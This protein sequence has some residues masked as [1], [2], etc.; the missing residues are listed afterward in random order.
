[1]IQ[2]SKHVIFD[3]ITYDRDQ[4]EIFVKQFDQCIVNYSE[5]QKRQNGGKQ[6]YGVP[7]GYNVVDTTRLDGLGPTEYSE[8]S[9]LLDKFKI[10]IP[11]EHVVISHY[12]VGFRLRPHT[13]HAC[14]ASIMF[15]I[16]PKDAGAELVFHD[17]DPP[18]KKAHDYK[19]FW[20]KI[21]Y[22]VKYSTEHPS[23]FSTQI[24]H[25][26]AT[27]QEPRIYLKF[28]VF[29]YTYEEMINLCKQG[30]LF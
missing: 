12:D 3:E 14:N 11:A 10:D 19:E 4:L 8:V 6:N 1:M 22:T 28:M 9:S 26:V 7:T 23:A 20:D 21:D 18:Y 24:P 17:I 25:S 29:N 2:H 27:V 16:M 5:W 30:K 13:D 15:P